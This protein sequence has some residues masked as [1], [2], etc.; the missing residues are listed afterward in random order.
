M[1]DD[2]ARFSCEP[3]VILG[4]L[5]AAILLTGEEELVR[6]AWRRFTAAIGRRLDVS[7]TTFEHSARVLSREGCRVVRV[8]VSGAGCRVRTCE[9]APDGGW[10]DGIPRRCSR[11]DV[12]RVA[13]EIVDHGAERPATRADDAPAAP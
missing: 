3:R 10:T 13:M 12:V 6:D 8:E 1:Q 9:A 4:D 11:A 5:A 7:L 2:S